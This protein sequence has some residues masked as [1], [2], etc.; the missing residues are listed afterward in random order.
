MKAF[1]KREVTA[2]I[3]GAIRGKELDLSDLGLTEVPAEV[4]GMRHLTSLTLNSN[5][6]A[7]LPRWIRELGKLT[8]LRMAYNGLR[9]MPAIGELRALRSLDL[10]LNEIAEI[11]VW[12]GELNRLERLMLG[13]NHITELPSSLG[14][15]QGLHDLDLSNNRLSRFPEAL[16][17]LHRLARL[18]LAFNRVRELP[19]W[20]DEL[21]GL[22]N[23]G[24]GGNRISELPLSI[25]RLQRLETLNLYE[26]HLAD[27]PP[28]LGRLRQLRD[29]TLSYN[30]LT[31][32]PEG[33]GSL[34]RLRELW[35]RGNELAELPDALEGLA[36]LELLD[37]AENE[38]TEL[39]RLLGRL[40]HLRDLE[41]IDN[42]LH[43]PPPEVLAQ[44]TASIL[45][46][47]RQEADDARLQ[48]T[49]KLLLVGEG[50][51]GKTCLLNALRGDPFDPE[52][53]TTH[54]IDVRELSLPHPEREGVLMTLNAWDFG[55][56]EIY[57]A[58]HQFFLTN[59]SLFLLVWNTRLGF[60]A[61]KLYYW[62]D[63]IH[64]RAPE[65]PVLIV[66]TH[67][68]ERPADLPI[69][70]LKSRYPQ[71]V[72][73][74]AVSSKTDLGIPELWDK[75][76]R[77]SAAL[78]LMGESWPAA[79]ARAAET[80]RARPENRIT[81]VELERILAD[82]GVDEDGRPVLARCLHELGH[83]LYFAGDPELRDTV[84]LSP[85]WVTERISRVLECD[86]IEDGLAIFRRE[87][88]D[89][90]WSDVDRG[91]W[92]RLLRLMERFDLSYRI[93]E[94]P[95]ERS[96][97]VER[98]S[99]DP[100]DYH[101]RWDAKIAEE[102]CKEVAMRFDL[103]ATRPAGIPTW[104]IAREHRFTT[105]TH[106]RYGALFTD[107][108]HGRHLALVTAPPG[109]RH[110][111]LAVRGPRPYSFFNLLK[112]GL[113]ETLRRFPGLNVRRTIPCPG[114]GG[115]PCS[116]EFEYEHLERAVERVPPVRELQC[117]VGFESLPVSELLFGIHWSTR[118]A[119]LEHIDAGFQ[120][121]EARQRETAERLDEL[122]ELAQRDFTYRF[123]RDQ[124]LPESH[125]PRVFTLTPDEGRDWPGREKL[126]GT[127]LRLQL[128]CEA[129]GA[130]H[131]AAG[132]P[133]VVQQPGRWLATMAPHLGRL[134]RVL[135]FVTPLVGPW[136]TLEQERY[137][138]LLKREVRLTE[139]LVRSLPDVER[140]RD[141]LS[142]LPEAPEDAPRTGDG[143]VGLQAGAALRGLR[144][145]LDELD[146]EQ[147]WGGLRKTLT[148]EGHYL[149]LCPHH[150]EDYRS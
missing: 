149:W 124:R 38:L 117:P 69:A 19:G 132:E 80:V 52:S 128:Y 145:L 27:L 121:S 59:R 25:A 33:I 22:S 122:I 48:W 16:R 28:W 50:G 37:V 135:K 64:S 120:R 10:G 62:L 23:L 40:P 12:F 17:R 5:R 140:A 53:E 78:P 131:P 137:A 51:V 15:L 102:G 130:W 9:E 34:Q 114:H 100:V 123:N 14:A 109:E 115:A 89:R 88:M 79:W 99:L 116:H 136:M 147:G 103:R 76:A 1:V 32:L 71:V 129:P 83:I 82:S 106:W 30:T 101:Q 81:D 148:P 66:A 92:D 93:P 94:D 58:T 26:N 60:E 21:R 31:H 126:R 45:A 7:K 56:Q 18:Q 24:L 68:D 133:Y 43:S 75:I 49:S 150:A 142:P 107:A 141:P 119:V 112:D 54:G 36:Q 127:K 86:E 98:L 95:E 144:V 46:F 104:F 146:P 61:G 85:E 6:I 39:P 118:D 11:P 29:L 84:L 110:V 3:E 91:L 42:P 2:R 77:E 139:A 55:G 73:A 65:S 35:L 108:P 67:V 111:T 74:A 113:E 72:G 47:L 96:L 90:I 41:V 20:I 125:C 57:H 4:R 70:D 97:V 138:E 13:A 63:T 105:G 44:G 87:H 143:P 8:E 134:I